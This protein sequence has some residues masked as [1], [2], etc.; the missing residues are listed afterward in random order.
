ML[1]FL[2]KE[3]IDALK[4]TNLEFIT[5]IRLRINQPI[6]CYFKNDKYYLTNNGISKNS[7]NKIIAKS[8]LLENII[9][10]VT[11][12]SIYAFND[13]IKNGFLTTKKGVRIGI[14]GECVFDKG[15]IITIKNY[16]SFCIRIPHDILGCS[17]YLYNKIYKKECFNTIIISP[18]GGG[19]TTI[20]KDLI[21]NFN[22]TNN[23]N[24]LVIDE[25]QELN[26]KGENV[27][28]I[29]NSNKKYALNYSI[30]SMCPQ[31]IFLDEISDIN[32]YQ[33]VIKTIQSGVKVIC[34]AH[35]TSI[36]DIT[37]KYKRI[38]KFFDRFI[39]LDG[40][41]NPGI[42]KHIYDEKLNEI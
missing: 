21:R 40:F 33:G 16:S 42:I 28:R 14:S 5:E 39:I 3:I 19:K 15:N 30:K 34:S 35:G 36:S 17:D 10:N 32:D 20:I 7:E 18:P 27:D 8:K 22:N 1:S 41:Y 38:N 12:N 31:I 2:S 29:I 13:N 25:R 11:E 24:I 26:A 9:L 6:I 23:Y 37:T 4:N